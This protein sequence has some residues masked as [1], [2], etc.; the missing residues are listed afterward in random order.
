MAPPKEKKIKEILRAQS[1]KLQSVARPAKSTSLFMQYIRVNKV[2][3]GGVLNKKTKQIKALWQGRWKKK[4]H[5]NEMK[6]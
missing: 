3:E 5:E 2:D 6:K 1:K 4:K